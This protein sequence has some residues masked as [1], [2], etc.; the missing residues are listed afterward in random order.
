MA[1]ELTQNKS[2]NNNKNFN[3]SFLTVFISEL[4]FC[5]RIQESRYIGALPGKTIGGAFARSGSVD[6]GGGWLCEARVAAA[7]GW[8]RGALRYPPGALLRWWLR[9]PRG[10]SGRG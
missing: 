5:K 4:F 9:A 2:P 7:A 8:R 3:K 10:G 6:G 1:F